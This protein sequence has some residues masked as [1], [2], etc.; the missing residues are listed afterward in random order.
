[1]R[2]KEFSKNPGNL[3][4][5]S[6]RVS[7]IAKQLKEY[8][9]TDSFRSQIEKVHKLNGNSQEIQKLLEKKL[10]SLRFAS[11]KKGLFIKCAVPSLRPD[12]YKKVGKS[13][14]LVEIER[15]K[16]IANNMEMSPL[17]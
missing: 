5:E 17:S 11:E 9:G 3:S 13:G 1:M 12:F 10:V 8:M 6:K 15:G 4:G 14:I 2:Y 7:S 16:T